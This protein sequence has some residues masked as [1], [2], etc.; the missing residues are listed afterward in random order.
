MP[1]LDIDIR[2]KIV[3]YLLDDISIEQL[4]DWFVS[5]SYNFLQKE[6]KNIVDLVSDIGLLLA[7][8]SNGDW[9]ENELKN[10]LR[11]MVE[12]YS[13]Y[14]D[15]IPV[16]KYGASAAQVLWSALRSKL[17]VSFDILYVGA[18]A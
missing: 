4:E 11:P 1:P 15:Y 7:E 5:A 14:I 18:S 12:S 13:V 8:Y 3:S 6:N 17:P 9:S 16:L 2:D 10:F